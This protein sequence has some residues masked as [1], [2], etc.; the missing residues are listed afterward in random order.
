M[1]HGDDATT[2]LETAKAFRPRILAECG[3]IE[4]DRRLPDD[5]AHELA[6]AGFFQIGRA[7][8]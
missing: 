1:A 6:R 5:L 3:R 2:L 4:S 8:V 7:H